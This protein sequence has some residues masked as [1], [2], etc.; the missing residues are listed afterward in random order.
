ML[1]FSTNMF[2]PT[3]SP[4]QMRDTG[5]SEIKRENTREGFMMLNMGPYSLSTSGGWGHLRPLPSEGC[6]V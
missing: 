1:E 6:Q 5:D 2:H 4:P 3:M